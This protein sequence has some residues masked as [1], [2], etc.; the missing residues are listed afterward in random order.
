MAHDGAV[1]ETAAGGSRSRMRQTVWDMVRS[2]ALVLAVV[3]VIV[4]LA[5]RPTPEAVRVVDPAPVIAQALTQAEFE[6]LAPSG[7]DEGWRPTSARW[8]PTAESGDDLVLHVGYVTPAEAYAQ[9]VQSTDTSSAFLA[10]QT[11]DG[12]ETGSQDVGGVQWQRWE[13]EKRRSLVRPGEESVVVVSGTASWEE[14]VALAAA[15]A[16]ASDVSPTTP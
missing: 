5:W 3:F 13:S 2:M 8:E 15:L 9:V 1:T 6:V 10:E 11:T 14:L 7:L 4:L 12:L 16:P